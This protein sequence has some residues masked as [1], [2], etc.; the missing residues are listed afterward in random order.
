VKEN[1]KNKLYIVS[2]GAGGLNY[3]TPEASQAIKECEVVV[4]YSKYAR[5]FEELLIG[6]ELY[7]SGMTY[8]THRCNRAI[9]YA[10][11]GKITGIISN[12][13]ANVFGMASIVVEIIEQKNL[14]DKIELISLPGITSFLATASKIGAAVSQD[15]AIISLSDKLT[16]INL[17]NKKVDLALEADFVLGIYNPKSKKRTQP[18]LNFLESLKHQD[19]KIA[20]IASNVGRKKEKITI[21]DTNDLIENGLEN[22]LILMSTLIIIGNSNTKLTSNNLVLTP[23]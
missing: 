13:D 7:T 8:E 22:K 2:S 20:V 15:F 12:G 11:D 1:I 10:L 14:W 6:K 9:E 21:T 16:D 18:Y 17:I 23:R 3:L 5:E 4:S 19:N